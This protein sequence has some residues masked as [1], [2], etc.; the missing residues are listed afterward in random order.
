MDFYLDVSF[1][2]KEKLGAA[3]S[4]KII[5]SLEVVIIP[6]DPTDTFPPLL[7]DL[8]HRLVF[9]LWPMNKRRQI[10]GK[11]EISLRHQWFIKGTIFRT[12]WVFRGKWNKMWSMNLK[13]F[14]LIHFSSRKTLATRRIFEVWDLSYTIWSSGSEL[15]YFP[16]L[17][18]FRVVLDASPL[19]SPWGS[20]RVLFL[21]SDFFLCLGFGISSLT[22]YPFYSKF[23]CSSLCRFHGWS[24]AMKILR[25]LNFQNDVKI[26]VWQIGPFPFKKGRKVN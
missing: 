4:R 10:E 20:L 2:K 15:T 13:T 12:S 22:G 7:V 21:I 19:V 1:S 6:F 9:S 17:C 5:N 3:Y 14:P 8:H 23:C 26:P 11:E 24:R 16:A 18:L 25:V